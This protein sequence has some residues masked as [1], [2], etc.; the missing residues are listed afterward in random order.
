MLDDVRPAE[1][2]AGILMSKSIAVAAA[3]IAV[4]L[5]CGPVLAAHVA[6]HHS[7][8]HPRKCADAAQAWRRK[9]GSARGTVADVALSRRLANE[10]ESLCR[11]TNSAQQ[12]KGAAIYERAILACDG[13]SKDPA[14]RY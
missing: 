7:S 10:A 5:G 8:G 14:L 2:R 13:S 11:S 3:V 12:E 1:R 9:I 4:G 6:A